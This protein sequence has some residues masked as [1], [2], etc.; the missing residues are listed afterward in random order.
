MVYLDVVVLLFAGFQN[1]CPNE[2]LIFFQVAFTTICIIMQ[3]FKFVWISCV[4]N[5]ISDTI[6]DERSEVE[7][8]KLQV[9]QY[10]CDKPVID[11]Q[12]QEIRFEIP[13]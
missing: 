4:F 6:C 2:R 3:V 1:F 7:C 8:S 9:G 10:L 5:L 12:T 13:N 11:T